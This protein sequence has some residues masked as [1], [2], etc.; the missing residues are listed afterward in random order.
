MFESRYQ[1]TCRKKNIKYFVYCICI[2]KKLTIYTF[3]PIEL[4]GKITV[5]EPFFVLCST[6]SDKALELLEQANY[7]EK[8]GETIVLYTAKLAE[9]MHFVNKEDR[10]RDKNGKG[11]ALAKSEGWKDLNQS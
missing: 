10:E 11:Q 8:S 5:Y 1:R 6:Y 4:L 3:N 2:S 9:T 7:V